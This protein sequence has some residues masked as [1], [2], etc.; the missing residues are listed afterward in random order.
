MW[1]DKRGH[2]HI[3]NHAYDTSQHDHCGS[4]T[5]S[6]H[7]FSIDGIEWHMV[8]P[9]VEPYGHTVQYDD[10]TS[11]TLVM[12]AMDFI[13]FDVRASLSVTTS[14]L[15]LHAVTHTRTQHTH[16]HTHTHTQ[17]HTHTHM[18]FS[19]SLIYIEKSDHPT[20]ELVYSC[21]CR[22]LLA[23][24]VRV[25]FHTCLF[26]IHQYHSGHNLSR[27]TTLERPGLHFDPTGQLT[28]INL[29]AD[30][31]TGDEGCAPTACT[32]CKYKDHAG[33]IVIK[34]KVP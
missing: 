5:L 10:G 21:T 6:A 1:I 22:L 32:N 7:Q 13:V 18:S 17:T 30:M 8:V 9:N 26:A 4:S 3:I 14:F 27:Y 24:S 12:P 15:Y 33:T 2:W 29:A 25:R 20:Y 34:L 16:T 11:H 31:I 19:L 28:H 23:G